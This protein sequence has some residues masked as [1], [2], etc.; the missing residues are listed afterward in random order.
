[1][2]L[3]LYTWP[4]DWCRAIVFIIFSKCDNSRKLDSKFFSW[5]VWT[6]KETPV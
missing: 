5:S 3:S 2:L 4:F 6:F 1:M